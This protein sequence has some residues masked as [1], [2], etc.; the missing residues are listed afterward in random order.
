MFKA[1]F[2]LAAAL[3]I[4]FLVDLAVAWWVMLCLAWAHQADARVPALT[5][6]ACFWIAAAIGSVVATS[7]AASNAASD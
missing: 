6:W 5:Y 4:L 1:L 2:V 7:A 3:G